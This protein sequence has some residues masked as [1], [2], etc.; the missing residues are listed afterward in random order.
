[1]S[2]SDAKDYLEEGISLLQKILPTIKLPKTINEDSKNI[3]SDIDT[4]VYTNKVN[5]TDRDG[6]EIITLEYLRNLTQLIEIHFKESSVKNRLKVYREIGNSKRPVPES[7]LERIM[8]FVLPKKRKIPEQ[9]KYNPTKPK[10][11]S[12]EGN[13]G[14]GKTSLLTRLAQH[15]GTENARDDIYIMFEPVDDWNSVKDRNG[16][17]ILNLFYEDRTKY[18]LAFQ[19][20]VCTTIR[21]R[22]QQIIDDSPNVKYIVCERSLTS[23]RTVFAQMLRDSGHMTDLEFSVY[24]EL[25]MD[26]TTQ[27]MEPTEMIYID[28]SPT[29]CLE[30]INKRLE[31]QAQAGDNGREGEQLIE[32]SYLQMCK[33]YHEHMP[34]I[35]RRINGDVS[36]S[37]PRNHWIS[38]IMSHMPQL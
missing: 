30:R 15:I 35:N 8:S 21:H 2:E 25:F 29:V 24:Q 36:D 5:L 26:H 12:I 32:L 23:S 28:T 20:L 31:E 13:I 6:Q 38:E 22:L 19:T 17:S 11:I 34:S 10:I 16:K 9:V 4:L 27:W 7:T 18:S 33:Q 37:T 14:S 1:L 3:Y